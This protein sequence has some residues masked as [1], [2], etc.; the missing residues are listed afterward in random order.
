MLASMCLCG[1]SGGEYGTVGDSMWV[2]L[3]GGGYI[4]WGKGELLRRWATWLRR[5]LVW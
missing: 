1:T 3:M 2:A 4:K 5:V